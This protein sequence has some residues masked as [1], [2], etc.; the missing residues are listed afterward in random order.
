MERDMFHSCYKINGYHFI[1]RVMGSTQ[2]SFSD[3]RKFGRQYAHLLQCGDCISSVGRTI[4]EFSVGSGSFTMDQ[5]NRRIAYLEHANGYHE[6][7]SKR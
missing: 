1:E 3:L 5:L 7:R 4:E 6:R 2:M